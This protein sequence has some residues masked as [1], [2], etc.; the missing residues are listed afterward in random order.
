MCVISTSCVNITMSSSNSWTKSS[1]STWFF[2]ISSTSFLCMASS[3]SSLAS[4][5]LDTILAI[6]SFSCKSCRHRAISRLPKII[7]FKIPTGN[8]K[9]FYRF[10][11]NRIWCELPRWHFFV[12]LRELGFCCIELLKEIKFMRAGCWYDS[13]NTMRSTRNLTRTKSYLRSIFVQVTAVLC[14]DNWH[15]LPH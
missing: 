4:L 11:C 2:F 15:S 1:V 10:T 9:S 8:S 13:F 12:H 7:C 3:P 14:L 6:S 5:P